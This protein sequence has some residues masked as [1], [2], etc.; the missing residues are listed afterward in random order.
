[1]ELSPDSIQ[2]SSPSSERRKLCTQ[3]R[4]PWERV[5]SPS[6]REL[7]LTTGDRLSLMLQRTFTAQMGLD[8]QCTFLTGNTLNVRSL[9]SDSIQRL[10][11]IS[12]PQK[13]PEAGLEAGGAQRAGAPDRQCLGRT[14]VSCYQE[15]SSVLEQG[16][17]VDSRQ[18][19]KV[20]MLDVLEA[21]FQLI[22]GPFPNKPAHTRERNGK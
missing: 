19:G 1:M 12:Y 7:K 15:T 3:L 22:R 21:G 6:L 11:W 20:R 10:F 17:R 9:S 5:R 2:L 16:Q 4:L 8:L 18:A 13:T 14:S